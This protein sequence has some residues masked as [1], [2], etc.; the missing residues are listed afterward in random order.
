MRRLE[1]EFDAAADSVHQSVVTRALEQ[2]RHGMQRLDV[3]PS[4]RHIVCHLVER[5]DPMRKTFADCFGVVVDELGHQLVLLRTDS[6][7]E[8]VQQ[9]PGWLTRSSAT[10]PIGRAHGRILTPF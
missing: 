4:R 8:R 9:I 5:F 7:D 6:G 1:V 2:A 3:S 10:E